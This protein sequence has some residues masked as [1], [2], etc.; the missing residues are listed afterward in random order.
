[1]QNWFHK[2]RIGRIQVAVGVS[3]SADP[4][5]VRA[6]L[7][8]CAQKNASVMNSPPAFVV[9]QDFGDSSLDFELRAYIWNYDNALQARSDLRFAIFKALKDAGVEIPFPQRDLH[10]R[11][12][13]T[14]GGGA[15]E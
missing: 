9:W 3:Y 5:Q 7:L 8:D 12:D 10:I 13:S 15:A 6:I 14:K 11:S 2:N 1:V 4:E